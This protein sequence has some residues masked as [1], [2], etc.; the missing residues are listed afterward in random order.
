MQYYDLIETPKTGKRFLQQDE[1]ETRIPETD[2]LVDNWFKPIDSL[3]YHRDFDSNG[4]PLVV[5]NVETKEETIPS[6]QYFL[7]RKWNGSTL[8]ELLVETECPY[9]RG[10][11]IEQWW[12][13]EIPETLPTYDGEGNETGTQ[14]NPAYIKRGVWE[15]VE[16]PLPNVMVIT[17]LQ[18]TE[19]LEAEGKLDNLITLLSSDSVLMF[20]WNAAQD[21]AIDYPLVVAMA[22]VLE[23]N[24]IQATFNEIGNG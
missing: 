5:E 14:P 11:V 20:K 9:N 8:I 22:P 6:G 24:D 15:E 12:G 17:K 21:L 3:C 13:E 16:Q 23:I 10:E 7:Y 1:E 19:W 18:L 2:P 4:Y